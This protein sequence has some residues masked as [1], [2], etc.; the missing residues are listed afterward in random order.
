MSYGTHV[1]PITAPQCFERA[2]ERRG[3]LKKHSALTSALGQCLVYFFFVFFGSKEHEDEPKQKHRP[4]FRLF[5]FFVVVLCFCY[6]AFSSTERRPAVTN[7]LHWVIPATGVE[8]LIT[9]SLLETVFLWMAS[10]IDTN[11]RVFASA[12]VS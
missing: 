9:V 12:R 11:A 7:R 2:N 10:I 5:F 1:H 4:R 3:K 6:L 8:A